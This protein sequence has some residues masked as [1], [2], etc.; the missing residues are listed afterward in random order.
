[1][2]ALYLYA[3]MKDW[4]NQEA[5]KKLFRTAMPNFIFGYTCMS[6]RLFWS[7]TAVK[8]SGIW[9][10]CSWINWSRQ[11]NLLVPSATEALFASKIFGQMSTVAILFVFDKYSS[12]MD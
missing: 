9:L 12:I 10:E 3:I 8:W 6:F 5:T 2:G 11:Q 4:P 1:M 7:L